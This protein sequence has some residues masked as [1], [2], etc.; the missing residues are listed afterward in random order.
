VGLVGSTILAVVVAIAVAVLVLI[1]STV[2][3]AV[4]AGGIVS[5]VSKVPAHGGLV[6]LP[7]ERKY[8]MT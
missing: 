1:G 4:D 7:S 5:D 8:R 6:G 2:V 3:F